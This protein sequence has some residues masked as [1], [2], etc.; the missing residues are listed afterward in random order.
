MNVKFK[1]LSAG[2]KESA[3]LL[4]PLI[5]KSKIILIDEGFAN[6][7]SS[8]IKK[9]LDLYQDLAKNSLVIKLK[10]F[11]NYYKTMIYNENNKFLNISSIS[12]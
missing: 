10:G 3:L 4:I 7:D 11:D 9:F 1:H 2:E 5:K 6:L 12:D 8:R